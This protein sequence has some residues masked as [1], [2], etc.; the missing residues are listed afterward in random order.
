M[1]FLA[2]IATTRSISAA[3]QR[4]LSSLAPAVFLLLAFWG[5]AV[6]VGTAGAKA[7]ELRRETLAIETASGKRHEI[8]AE[9]A[10]TPAA[11]GT[12]LMFRE[13]MAD[14]AGML[15]DFHRE[16][17]VIFWMKNTL[18]SLDM[19]FVKEDG[20]IARIAR[21]T[22]PLSEKI[23]P[24]GEPVRFVLELVGGT[25]ARLGIAKGDRLT[26]KAIGKAG[27]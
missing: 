24:S 26:G 25:S 7:E 15:F 17:E 14:D 27:G 9:I 21:D 23:I 5:A 11:R 6:L 19:L 22:T 10:D 3:G 16:S 8:I 18:I 12:G 20:T 2:R 1:T 4:P 13:A